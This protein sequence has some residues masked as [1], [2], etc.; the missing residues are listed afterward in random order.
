MKL[1]RQTSLQHVNRELSRENRQLI[2]LFSF[3]AFVICL[4]F[5]FSLIPL[6]LYTVSLHMSV[7]LS[8]NWIHTDFGELWCLQ[9]HTSFT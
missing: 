5:Y 4:C 7:M 2:A 6:I 9:F 1:Q 3:N 8:K